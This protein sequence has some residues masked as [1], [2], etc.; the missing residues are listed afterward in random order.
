MLLHFTSNFVYRRDERHI[1]R[2]T[3]YMCRPSPIATSCI[4][5]TLRNR[6]SLSAA[7]CSL[8]SVH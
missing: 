6:S 3:P 5:R 8:G 2:R 1:L 4:I 7:L